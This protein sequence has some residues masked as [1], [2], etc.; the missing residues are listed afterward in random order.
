MK[1]KFIISA[2]SDEALRNVDDQ[3]ELLNKLGIEYFE[4]RYVTPERTII[5]YSLDEARELKAKMDARNIKVSCIGS[6][7]GKIKITDPF[8]P[9]LE[10]LRHCIEIAK[11]LGTKNIRTFSFWLPEGDAPEKWRDEVMS[12]LS[13]MVAI[14]EKEGIVLL[15]E[16]EHRVYGESAENCLDIFETIKS[17][18]LSG[19]FDPANFI[20][21]NYEPYSAYEMLKDHITYFHMKD[22]VPNVEMCP[23]GYGEGRVADVLKAVPDREEP[24]FLTIEPHLEEYKGADALITDEMMAEYPERLVRLFVVAYNALVKLLKEIGEY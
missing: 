10:R 3:L 2:F 4:P 6:W 17:P 7:L 24:Y 5:D 14:A 18:A 15:H 16:N 12:R 11:I 21:F 13:Q 23:V 8:E 1:K 19:T 9:H 20:Y 22:A